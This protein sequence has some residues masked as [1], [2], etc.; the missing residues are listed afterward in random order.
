MLFLILI[1]ISS[2]SKTMLCLNGF[3]LNVNI[4]IVCYFSEWLNSWCVTSYDVTFGGAKPTNIMENG[5]VG[6]M[7]EANGDYPTRTKL[8]MVC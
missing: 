2:L 6:A 1:C 3:G 5:L 8:F 4:C 7:S